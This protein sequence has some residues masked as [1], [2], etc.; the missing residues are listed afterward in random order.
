MAKVSLYNMTGTATGEMELK[1]SVFA[2]E[3]NSSIVQE[4]VV[5]QLANRRRGTASTKRRDEVRGGG[6]K[7][8]RQKGTG[9]ARVGSIRSP[10]WVGGGSIFGPKPRKY[11][12]K[13]SKK[14]TQLALRTVLSERLRDGG[15]IVL[16]KVEVEQIKSKPV[17]ELLQ[18]LNAEEKSLFVLSKID[19]KFK[20]SVRNFSDVKLCTTDNINAYD[21]LRYNKIIFD[22]SAIT[23]V[24]QSLSKNG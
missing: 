23:L 17:A 20:K 13:T 9:R 24:E 10:L 12:Q 11:T 6:I 7:P 1:D 15:I 21:L 16:D 18:R 8:W 5:A 22:Q 2:V 14:K 19:E 3:L 4:V